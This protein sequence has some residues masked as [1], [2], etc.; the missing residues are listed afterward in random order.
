MYCVLC[1]K[2]YEEVMSLN[3]DEVEK[4][5]KIV[6]CVLCYEK[7]AEVMSLNSDKVVKI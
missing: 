3:S 1:S 2:K 4:T 6:Y 7:Y 5:M